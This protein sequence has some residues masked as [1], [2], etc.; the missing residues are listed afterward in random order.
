MYPLHPDDR[1][2]LE[3]DRARTLREA[4]P[5]RLPAP[6]PAWL[7]PTEPVPAGPSTL[8]ARHPPAPLSHP[9]EPRALRAIARAHCAVSRDPCA[10]RVR[11]VLGSDPE[12]RR[13][14]V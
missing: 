7:D 2:R 6:P 5:R 14:G 11:N 9:A 8:G 13:F 3:E 12:G 4:R 10:F 1:L